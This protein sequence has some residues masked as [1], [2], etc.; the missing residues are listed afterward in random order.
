METVFVV[1]QETGGRNR[2]DEGNNK[3]FQPDTGAVNDLGK[4]DQDIQDSTEEN[5]LADHG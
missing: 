4:R 3:T 2:K 5:C 1:G